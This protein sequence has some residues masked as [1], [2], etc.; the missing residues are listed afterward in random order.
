[1]DLTID[2]LGLTECAINGVLNI[3]VVERKVSTGKVDA[4]S[5]KDAIFTNGSSWIHPVPQSMR[6]MAMLLSSL[7]VFTDRIGAKKMEHPTQDA[8]LH[9]FN[10]FTRFPP[11][12]RAIHILMNGKSPRDCERAALAQALY[13]VLKGVVPAQLIKSDMTRIFE[14]SRLLF[15]LIFES[16][17][18]AKYF[19][20]GAYCQRSS[21]PIRACREGLLR[22]L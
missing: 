16:P 1:M 20:H 18:F 14:G 17:R 13:E 10:L 15:G 8:V 5:G 4:E 7:R 12:I 19:H 21:D 3:Y 6:G 11:A 22:S 2:E 9:I